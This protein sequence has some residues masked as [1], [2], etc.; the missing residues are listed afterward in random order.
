VV[1]VVEV[2]DLVGT[3]IDIVFGDG[4][5]DIDVVFKIDVGLVLGVDLAQDAKTSDVTVRQISKV[6][7]APLFI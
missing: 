3:V 7:I 6:E 5:T 1:L 2:G 4:F